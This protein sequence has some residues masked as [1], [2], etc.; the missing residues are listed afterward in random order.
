MTGE[1]VWYVGCPVVV[2]GLTAAGVALRRRTSS[3]PGAPSASQDDEPTL[4]LAVTPA[5]DAAAS[6][7]LDAPEPPGGDGRPAATTAPAARVVLDARRLLRRAHGAVVRRH[8]ATTRGP[9]TTPQGPAGAEPAPAQRGSA[10]T[11]APAGDAVPECAGGGT[12]PARAQLRRA[13]LEGH[14]QPIAGGV[15]IV[16][17]PMDADDERQA[18][19]AAWAAD[20][21][22]REATLAATFAQR[23]EDAERALRLA[24]Q[25][26]ALRVQQGLE[27][28]A[29]AEEARVRAEARTRRWFMRLDPELDAPT[30]AQRSEMAASLGIS[31]P[32]AGKLL[33]LAYEQEE[34]P[35]VRARILG[36]LVAGSHLSVSDPFRSAVQRGGVERA[37]AWETLKPRQQD[38]AWIAPLL[39]A[40]AAG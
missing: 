14:E 30:V 19:S 29:V 2:A 17:F 23:D 25:A 27:R 10:A 22:A 11:T 34:E 9:A 36:A 13:D 33:C 1:M 31:A 18:G 24:A 16:E 7:P 35:R 32:W 37:A 26:D 12:E 3:T 6:A 15:G 38:A 20:V 39:D 4:V 8:G 28:V 5:A 21:S 40:V